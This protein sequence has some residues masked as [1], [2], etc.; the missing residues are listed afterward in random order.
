MLK[1]ARGAGLQVTAHRFLSLLIQLA[2]E[3]AL[4][5]GL[6]GMIHRSPHR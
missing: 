5:L 4:K 3:I 2:V 1:A 6:A